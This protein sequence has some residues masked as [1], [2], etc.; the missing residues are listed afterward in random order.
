ML[1]SLWAIVSFFSSFEFRPFLCGFKFPH[2]AS[3]CGFFTL[4]LLGAPWALSDW[5]LSSFF[6]PQQFSDTCLPSFLFSLRPPIIQMMTCGFYLPVLQ[7]CCI[8][9]L[10]IPM[11]ARRVAV[12]LLGEYVCSAYVIHWVISVI[13]FST[14]VLFKFHVIL[15]F[16]SL[17]MMASLNH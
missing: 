17:L 4:I 11:L 16:C 15:T 10:L 7:F 5:G 1:A 12:H 8:F 6:N 3:R 14:L 9:Q 2:N 13:T